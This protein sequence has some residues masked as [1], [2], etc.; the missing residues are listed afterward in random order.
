VARADGLMSVTL[1]IKGTEDYMAP[2]MFRGEGHGPSVDVYSLGMMLYQLLNGHRLPFLPLA[3]EPIACHD[4]ELAKSKR[5]SGEPLPV[6]TDA[7]CELASVVLKAC[8][9][10]PQDRY[11][12]AADLLEDLRRIER[13]ENSKAT[14]SGIR[15]KVVQEA[16]QEETKASAA[17]ETQ[18]DT[19]AS[20]PQTE[21]PITEETRY[22]FKDWPKGTQSVDSDKA[23][24]VSSDKE[25]HAFHEKPRMHCLGIDLSGTMCIAAYWYETLEE[26]VVLPGGYAYTRNSSEDELDELFNVLARSLEWRPEHVV[27]S[28][29]NAYTSMQKHH[30]VNAATRRAFKDADVRILCDTTALALF[31]HWSAHGK[32]ASNAGAHDTELLACVYRDGICDAGAYSIDQDV[33]ETLARDGR[34]A[35]SAARLNPVRCVH[36][37]MQ[38]SRN[39]SGIVLCDKESEVKLGALFSQAGLQFPHVLS[40]GGGAIAQGAAFKAMTLCGAI[41]KGMKEVAVLEALA[42]PLFIDISGEASCIIDRYTTIPIEREKVLNTAT[43]GDLVVTL[44]EGDPVHDGFRSMIGS[45]NLGRPFD[46]S[47]NRLP[48]FASI[49][50]DAGETIRLVAYKTEMDGSSWLGA[51]NVCCPKSA[52]S[53]DWNDSRYDS[54]FKEKNVAR[55]VRRAVTEQGG[56]QPRTKPDRVKS[57][58][59]SQRQAS[60]GCTVKLKTEGTKTISVKVPAGVK[61]GSKLMIRGVYSESADYSRDLIINLKVQEL[62]ADV[63]LKTAQE[64]DDFARKQGLAYKGMSAQAGFKRIAEALQKNEEVLMPIISSNIA[65]DKGFVFKAG[66]EAICA[67]ALT[68]Q[69]RFLVMPNNQVAAKRPIKEVLVYSFD[70]I[71]VVREP[72]NLVRDGVMVKYNDSSGKKKVLAFYVGRQNVRNTLSM[73]QEKL[74]PWIE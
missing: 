45:Y 2:E 30:I 58:T 56:G 27:I 42:L 47:G 5:L 59:I 39:Y 1:S 9:Y 12:N 24:D 57:I 18:E 32:Q 40:E 46:S 49:A 65:T 14:G 51:M 73:L 68:S 28:V 21:A 26:P 62:T 22:V 13:G 10:D 41:P 36:E 23:T 69:R 70:S 72:Y 16:S 6:P 54:V 20:A 17:R 33:I 61:D 48:V 64:M 43:T 50:I 66:A 15:S 44:F 74:A 8:A 38:T 35:Q 25:S 34:Y 60:K 71:S 52:D 55:K 4:R 31:W 11:Q 63:R 19:G 67:V 29:P 3:P 37:K 7:S 53:S